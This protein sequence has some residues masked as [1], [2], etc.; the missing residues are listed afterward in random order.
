MQNDILVIMNVCPED[1]KKD[2]GFVRAELA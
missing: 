2:I 1:I